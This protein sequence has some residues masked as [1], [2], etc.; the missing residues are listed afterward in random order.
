MWDNLAGSPLDP[1]SRLRDIAK[2]R[3]IGIQRV[4]TFHLVLPEKKN[5]E[6]RFGRPLHLHALVVGYGRVC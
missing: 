2:P 4:E 1:F 6:A 5:R 3:A